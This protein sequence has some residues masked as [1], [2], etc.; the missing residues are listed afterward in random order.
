MNSKSI[1]LFSISTVAILSGCGDSGSKFEGKWSCNAGALGTLAV[2]IRSNGGDEYII[3]DF[4]MIGKLS[5]TYKDGKL[6]GPEGA[7]FSI[8]KQSGKLLGMNIC[9]MSRVE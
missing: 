3:D 6:I 9:E 5:V 1:W 8:D 2:S 4:P 7:E